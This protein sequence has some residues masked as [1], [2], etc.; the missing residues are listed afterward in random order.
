MN[1][2]MD[3]KP[4]LLNAIGAEFT[5]K[6]QQA[7]FLLDFIES[8]PVS[9]VGRLE[10]F[11]HLLQNFGLVP[12]NGIK[13]PVKPE[14][15]LSGEEYNRII[16]RWE[17]YVDPVFA[18]VYV[19]E[20]PLNEATRTIW[21]CLNGIEPRI[22]RIVNLAKLLYSKVVPYYPEAGVCIRPQELGYVLN[23]VQDCAQRIKNLIDGGVYL[24]LSERDSLILGIIE[25]RQDRKERIV[26]F[27]LTAKLMMDANQL[28]QVIS[29]ISTLSALA[30]L[31]S[32]QEHNCEECDRERCPVHPSN[33]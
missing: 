13:V 25:S 28:S 24:N 23:Q 6:S 11:G 29:G 4:A 22:G 12:A 30:R 18:Q 5:M 27:T 21:A 15:L 17:E 20:P 8:A 33:R 31:C 26:L 3:F 1:Q 9:Q 19:E 16:S 10:L 32:K 2:K 14:Y 7:G